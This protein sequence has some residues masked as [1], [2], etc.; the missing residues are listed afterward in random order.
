MALTDN[1]VNGNNKSNKRDLPDYY[2]LHTDIALCYITICYSVV[3]NRLGVWVNGGGR[4]RKF[5][6]N[7]WEG[8]KILENLI[9]RVGKINRIQSSWS[10]VSYYH[11]LKTINCILLDINI[12]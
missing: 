1:R 7:K 5:W 6:I 9:A 10:V 12:N 8:W 3:Y 11:S 4:V 2:Y